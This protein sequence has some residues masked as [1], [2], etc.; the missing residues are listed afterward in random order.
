MLAMLWMMRILK[1]HQARWQLVCQ[2][3]GVKNGPM[4]QVAK[5]ALDKS[6]KAF[7]FEFN[8]NGKIE[9]IDISALDPGSEDERIA[10]W[11]GLTTYSS[12]F[13]EVVRT[14]VNESPI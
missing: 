14:A 12:R 11:G 6:Y 13:A 10:G 8:E 4:E 3:F 5:S 1:E 9:S 2:A 7:L